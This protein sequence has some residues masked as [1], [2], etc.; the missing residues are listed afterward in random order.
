M[1]IL[2]SSLSIVLPAYNEEGA[3]PATLASVLAFVRARELD[4]EIIVVDD[5]STDRTGA[6]IAA[7]Q[8][9]SPELRLLQH[10]R[11]RGYGEALRSGFTAAR[12]DWI[13]LMDADGQFDIR[14]LDRFFAYAGEY[15]MILGYRVRRA[16]AWSRKVLTWGYTRLMG[17]FFG[18]RLQDHDCAFKLF[19]RSAWE[20]TQPIHSTDHKIFTVEWLR[21]AQRRGLRLKELPVRHYPRTTGSATGARPDVIWAM[22]KALVRLQIR[23]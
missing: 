21:N 10:E 23:G 2:P 4:A 11:N 19:R 6:L 14:E 7:A 3:V 1:A 16:D 9:G 15:D 5:G 12:H 22:V 13:F 8:R 20:A 17:L 18:L